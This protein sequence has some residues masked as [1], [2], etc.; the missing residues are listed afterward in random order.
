MNENSEIQTKPQNFG[1]LLF[2]GFVQL[3][4]LLL[5]LLIHQSE[6]GV[7]SAGQF[8]TFLVF[9]GVPSLLIWILYWVICKSKSKILRAVL[10]LFVLALP[11]LLY[12]LLRM[13]FRGFSH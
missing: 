11:V 10:F 4:L 13:A 2:A 6:T 3:V 9:L 12:L 5:Y 7:S 1:K 8:A